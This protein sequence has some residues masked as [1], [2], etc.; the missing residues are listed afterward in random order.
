MK[1]PAALYLSIR[2]LA[3]R[4]AVEQSAPSPEPRPEQC[5]A[6]AFLPRGAGRRI[7]G[8]GSTVNVYVNAYTTDE[9]TQKF[10][11]ALIDSRR[12]NKRN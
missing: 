8:A 12:W 2:C 7:V 1:R 11:G 9:E 6:L 3:M 4:T 5:S 10:A